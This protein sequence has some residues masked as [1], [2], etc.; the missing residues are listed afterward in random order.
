MN[1]SRYCLYQK[2]R[3]LEN[4]IEKYEIKKGKKAKEYVIFKIQA[5][6]NKLKS[7]KEILDQDIKY[8]ENQEI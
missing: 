1:M 2:I 4:I 6:I 5:E 8:L 7:A 3:K